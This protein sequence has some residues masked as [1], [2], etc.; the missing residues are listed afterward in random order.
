MTEQKKTRRQKLEEL[1]AQ[2]PN[3]AFS[4]YGIA[5]ECARE[6]DHATAD[7]HYRTL[8]QN[9]PDYVPAYL[10]Y[11]QMLAQDERR[12]EAKSVLATGIEAATR[13]G[14]QHARS[15]MEFL[16]DELD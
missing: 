13:Q 16:L 12:E 10:M 14:N 9:S 4:R 8:L 6:G 1:L 3:D 15:E 11:A 5:L 2:N 7:S